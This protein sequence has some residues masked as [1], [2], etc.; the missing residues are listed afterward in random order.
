M[1]VNFKNYGLE[2]YE[3]IKNWD[4]AIPVG[5]G[6]M[7]CLIYGEKQLRFAIDR[8]DLWDNRKVEEAQVKEFTYKNLIKLSTGDDH[9][10]EKKNL[11][12]DLCGRHNYP[13]KLSAGRIILD[14]GEP[15]KNYR[16]SLNIKTAIA[17]VKT[18]EHEIT[19]FISAVRQ[20]GVIRVSGN[21]KIDI[22]IPSYL[23]EEKELNYP[24]SEVIRDGDYLYFKQD[25]HTEYNYAMILYVKKCKD[26]DEIYYTVSTSDDD[27]DCLAHG[28]LELKTAEQ[29]GYEA[30]LK[31]HTRWWKN[32][33]QKSSISIGD[34]DIEKTY[35][36]SWYLFASTSREG[37]YPMPLQGVWTA[38]NDQLPPWKGDYHHDTN[39]QMSYWGYGK[40]N[41][42][43]QGRVFADY[44]WDLRA[45][46]KE[47]AKKFYGV[48]GYLLV[49]CSSLKGEY[50]GGWAQ[51]SL[52]PTMT[53]WAAKAFDDY[54]YYSG[55]TEF[56]REKAYPF[57]REVESAI[58]GLFIEKNGK[59]YLP[60]SSSPEIYEEM[61]ENFSI[62]NTNFDQSLLLYMYKTLIKFCDELGKDSSI[63]KDKFAKLDNIY[64][65]DDGVI[66]LSKERRMPYS[67][68]H[69]SHLMSIY[70]LNLFHYDRLPD[71]ELIENS[72]LEIEQLGAGWW[73]GFSFPWCATLYSRMYNG[74]AAYEKLRAFNI[75]YL[76]E[77]GFHL[78]GDFKHLGASQWHYR[79]FTLEALFA[80]CDAV[81]EMLLQDEKGYIEI[82]A[83][84]PEKWKKK[85][86]FDNLRVNRGVLVSAE[87]KDGV[88]TS[89][90][91][92][93]QN[94]LRI[95]V[96]NN[97]AGEN[98]TVSHNGT[99][100]I[101][102]CD[103]G[104][105]DINLN[106]GTT[107]V[108]F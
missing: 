26:Y 48:D 23:S 44:L 98:I 61:R 40:A 52:S 69:F 16:S 46:M 29:I 85:A 45:V 4:E 11:L 72:M 2:F 91:F 81:Q 12:F 41:R 30:L 20:V 64:I 80:Y 14:I 6:R 103:N 22:H 51:F 43:E 71:K 57:F 34:K 31:E 35:Y 102:V 88:V 106:E 25:T 95:K 47:F 8:I 56:L 89:L 19:S 15:D 17:T 65:S 76:S 107:V 5:N 37:S 27:R 62:G 39:T 7:G 100:R 79:V 38:D 105:F 75:A 36:R 54:Y 73:V 55:D 9:D 32:Y 59:Y 10:W 96:K 83:S 21:Y 50:V 68:R 1:N 3:S 63:Y 28:M 60:L 49:A 78:N 67:H 92:H 70:P 84:L 99:E 97:F 108:I 66:M 18:A 24:K 87:M 101:I 82:F 104:F 58:S 86:S 94:A 77:N 93:S 13:T 53:I 90:S 42:L 74:N 33:W